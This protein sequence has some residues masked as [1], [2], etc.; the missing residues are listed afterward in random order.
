MRALILLLSV[1]GLVFSAHSAKAGLSTTPREMSAPADTAAV[2]GDANQQ[3]EDQIGLT[4]AKRLEVQR[5]LTRLGFRTRLNGK[6]DGQTRD[7]IT[8]WQDEHGYPKT[9]FL[10]TAQHEALLSDSA[11]AMKTS[12]A[13][14]QPRRRSGARAHRSHGVGGP[15]GVI[16]HMV[17]GLF[18]R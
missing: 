15:I 4:R 8:R 9:G 18:R 11:A 13:D 3:A 2:T 7:A 6:F 14:D 1:L 10:N 12:R 5:G 17:G 16:G